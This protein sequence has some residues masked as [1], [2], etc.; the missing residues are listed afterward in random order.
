MVNT[1]GNPI[2]KLN[3]LTR[4]CETLSTT[5]NNLN[6]A[7]RQLENGTGKIS[8]KIQTNFLFTGGTVDAELH[9]SHYKQTLV[10]CIGIMI[11]DLSSQYEGLKNK[12]DKAKELLNSVIGDDEI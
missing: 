1:M 12:L 8:L 6:I 9:S 5:I 3:E 7:K 2:S 11:E 10:D 4:L